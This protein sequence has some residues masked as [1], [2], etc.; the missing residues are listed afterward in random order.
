ML[1]TLTLIA[2]AAVAAALFIL[3]AR[4]IARPLARL[5]AVTKRITQG[6]WSER[7]PAEGVAELK[8]LAADF[9]EMTDAVERDLA[10]PA[11]RA[12]SALQTIA[13]RVPGAVFQFSVDEDGALTARFFSRGGEHLDFRSFAREVIA[14]DRG[15]WL[16]GML[17]A[18]RSGGAWHHEYRVHADGGG[19]AW[20]EAQRARPRT[21]SSTATSPTSPS[22]RRSRRS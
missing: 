7:A 12:S 8:Q 16:D 11:R 5:T 2:L 20:M 15:A 21:A 10:R 19:I 22:A 4:R 18:A 13:D 3:A 1:Q 14:D 17:A 6:D 9:N